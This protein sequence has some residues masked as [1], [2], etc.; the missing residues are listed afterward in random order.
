MD[1]LSRN[2]KSCF[3]KVTKPNCDGLIVAFGIWDE[4][5]GLWQLPLV[6]RWLKWCTDGGAL[7]SSLGDCGGIPPARITHLHSMPVQNLAAPN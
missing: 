6:V 3:Y 2:K 5:N 4:T 1:D 7:C